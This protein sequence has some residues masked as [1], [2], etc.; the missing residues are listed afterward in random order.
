LSEIAKAPAVSEHVGEQGRTPIQ[1]QIDWDYKWDE[2]EALVGFIA[3]VTDVTDR[4]RAEGHIRRL[5]RVY[6]VL[7][8]INQAIV[9][10]REPQALFEKACRVAVEKGGFRMA[11]VGLIGRP[12]EGGTRCPRGGDKRLPGLIEYR[13]ERRASWSRSHGRCPARGPARDLQ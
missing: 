11:W 13:V 6:A 8:D 10:I 9:R 5:N 1:V 12:R 7:S 2:K 4:Q 3:I